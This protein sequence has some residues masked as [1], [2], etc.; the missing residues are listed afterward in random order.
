MNFKFIINIG[1][2][3]WINSLRE[4]ISIIYIYKSR[5]FLIE[6]KLFVAT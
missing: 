2:N 3:V 1:Y 4:F 5:G 6:L